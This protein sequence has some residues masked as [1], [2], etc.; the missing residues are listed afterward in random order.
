MPRRLLGILIILL[1]PTI[2]WAQGEIVLLKEFEEKVALAEKI[3]LDSLPEFKMQL[4]FYR[5]NISQR[6]QTRVRKANSR[7]NEWIRLASL[8]RSLPQRISQEELKLE[9]LRMDS[10]YAELKTGVSFDKVIQRYSLEGGGELKWIPISFLLQEWKACLSSLKKN[11]IAKPFLSP[12][13]IHIVYW[14]EK[15]YRGEQMDEENII[16]LGDDEKKL[17]DCLLVA[18]LEKKYRKPVKYTEKDLEHYFESFR[19]SYA[20]D[21]PHYRG[22][23]VHCKDKKESKRIKKLLKKRRFTEWGKML[24][25]SND[26]ILASSLIEI[27]IFQI[28]T[29]KYVDKLVFGCGDYEP[30]DEFPYTFV[31]GKKLKKGPE[32]YEDVKEKVL[33]DYLNTHRNDWLYELR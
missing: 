3:G 18:V 29:N 7:R 13:G 17:R 9:L 22:A 20:W 2:G 19:S 4:D 14:V 26:G 25:N 28:G 6:V 32:N 8:T 5:Q 1:V 30:L 16:A 15:E 21:L 27:G 33:K 11:E 23:V 31:I 24:V 10:V 12:L